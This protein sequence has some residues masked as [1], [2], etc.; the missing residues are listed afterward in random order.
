[1]AEY[2]TKTNLKAIRIPQIQVANTDHDTELD[3]CCKRARLQF[4]DPALGK[5][6]DTLPL[7]SVPDAI[8]EITADIAAGIYQ[9]DHLYQM[10]GEMVGHEHPLMKRGLDAL[11]RYME[12]T[13]TEEGRATRAVS[14]WRRSSS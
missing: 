6:E 9:T 10:E 13:Y 3:N 1:M 7:T 2:A 11:D 5:H 8:V 14:S 12:D 4:V